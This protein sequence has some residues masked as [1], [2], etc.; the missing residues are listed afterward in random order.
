MHTRQHSPHRSLC[1][2]DFKFTCLLFALKMVPTKAR[3]TM[4]NICSLHSN[5]CLVSFM[6]RWCHAVALQ[7][8]C[9]INRYKGKP[10]THFIYNRFS[11]SP[12]VQPG[13]IIVHCTVYRC[14]CVEWKWNLLFEF[15]SLSARTWIISFVHLI[16]KNHEYFLR[17]T[18]TMDKPKVCIP[19]EHYSCCELC[20]PLGLGTP[21]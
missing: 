15:M 19:F 6:W 18:I 11:V 20:L 8:P 1:F 9:K 7:K 2:S 17:S 10:H 13:S 16:R 5:V 12:T 21:I 3:L 14:Q 4:G